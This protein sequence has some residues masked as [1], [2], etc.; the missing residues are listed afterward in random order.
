MGEGRG[1]PGEQQEQGGHGARDLPTVAAVPG[2]VVGDEAEP[3]E[4]A[5]GHEHASAPSVIVLASATGALIVAAWILAGRSADPFLAVPGFALLAAAMVVLAANRFV[6]A[7]LGAAHPHVVDRPQLV[8]ANS[9]ASTLC[10]LAY[11]L[12]L[13]TTGIALPTQG[14]AS[15]IHALLE[16][17]IFQGHLGRRRHEGRS[18]EANQT[19][20][21]KPEHAI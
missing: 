7:G 9:L 4:A 2:H 13:A 11:G 1:S 17:G 14:S 21:Q 6:L 3:G 19:G 8:T 15:L 5:P 18:T 16:G 12:G 20:D 10:A